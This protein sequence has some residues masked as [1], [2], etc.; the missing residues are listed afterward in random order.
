MRKPGYAKMRHCSG[1]DARG[2]RWHG[3]NRK[4]LHGTRSWVWQQPVSDS[5]NKQTRSV[6]E[7]A[8]RSIALQNFGSS[9]DQNRQPDMRGFSEV[10]MKS[11]S[12]LPEVPS[13]LT[14]W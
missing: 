4:I 3:N 10:P 7:Y 13:F 2:I 1:F 6:G 11:V 14:G 12:K 9:P 5:C 8:I